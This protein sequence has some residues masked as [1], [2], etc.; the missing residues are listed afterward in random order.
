MRITRQKLLNLALK[1]TEQQADHGDVIS[2]YVIG[3]VAAGSPLIGGTGDVDLVLIHE[4]RPVAPRQIVP[5][6]SE[7]H[8]DIHH[9]A[10]Q[11][12]A[13][14][15]EL[16][17]HPWH[18]PAMCEPAFL[19]DPTHFFEWAQAAVR[20]QFHRADHVHAR[21]VAFLDRSRK[22]AAA[23]E[24]SESWLSRYF[25]AIL[26]TVNAV[27]S[28]VGFPP[29]GRRVALQLRKRLEASGH[30]DLYDRFLRL[31]GANGVSE[32]LYADWTAQWTRAFDAASDGS[33]AQR[34][35]EHR[36]QQSRVRDS[37]DRS[38]PDPEFAPG[39]RS[40]FLAAFQ[41]MIEE[42]DGEYTLFPMLRS[43]EKAIR[44]TAQAEE[45]LRF[46]ESVLEALQLSTAH[47]RH[48]ETELEQLQDHVEYV[49]EGWA[50]RVGA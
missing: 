13:Q 8:L 15:V 6:S 36:Q 47:R 42:G 39:R 7:V 33:P 24:R 1:E 35:G 4:H 23:I 16:R 9:H 45:H 48:R 14:P 5:L 38:P 40:Y 46:W 49:L 10:K 31:L 43:W 34:A 21:A 3:S 37:T 32:R 12:Y 29:T 18:G 30:P 17:H 11:L 27:A 44:N 28:L 19:Y 2:G 41:T 22:T 50:D 26:E 25:S 20:G